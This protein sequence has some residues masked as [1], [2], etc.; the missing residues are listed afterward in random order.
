[1]SIFDKC[2]E[3][4][5]SNARMHARQYKSKGY[6]LSQG[7]LMSSMQ[8]VEVY[9]TTHEVLERWFGMGVFEDVFGVVGKES[10]DAAAEDSG[11]EK[12]FPVLSLMLMG[13]PMLQGKRRKTA[14]MTVVCEDGQFK[15]GL[16]DRDRDVSL[17]VSAGTLDGAMT[18]LEEALNARPVAWRRIT[19]DRFRGSQRR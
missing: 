18:T 1:M 2:D 3:L 4:R 17:W 5:K 13:T 8:A 16:R 7:D 14:T 15:L 11:L 10:T 12:R 9:F 6:W 19:D